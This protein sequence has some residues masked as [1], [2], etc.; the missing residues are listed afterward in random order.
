MKKTS[1]VLIDDHAI[2]R[3]GLI[4]L[5]NTSGLFNIVGDAGNGADGI[6]KALRL[7]PDVIIMDLMMPQM[8]GVETTKRLLDEWPEAKILILTTFGTSDGLSR[9][10]EAGARGAILKNADWK[11]FQKAVAAIAAGKSYVSDEVS[12]IMA[13]DPPIPDLSP[14]QREILTLVV[15]GRRNDYIAA[16]LNISSAVVKEHMTILFHKMGVS[17][18][19]EA[20]ALTLRKHL[21][22]I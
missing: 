2:M 8:D 19:T 1:I 10:L 5:L 4:S 7:H 3:M 17:N 16:K 14:R 9:A 15:E 6:R 22:K 18:R 11:V 13:D 21:L 20:V 12:Q